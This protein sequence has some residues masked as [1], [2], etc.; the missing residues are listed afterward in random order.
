[1]L[2]AW[3]TMPFARVAHPLRQEDHLLPLMIPTGAGGADPGAHLFR[4][5]VIGWT[6]SGYRFG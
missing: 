3:K 6:L 4:D 2:T 1:M 5:P